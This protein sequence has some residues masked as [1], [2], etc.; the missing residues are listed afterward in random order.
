MQTPGIFA[1]R[2]LSRG[3]ARGASRGSLF[4]CLL[5][6]ALCGVLFAAFEVPAPVAAAPPGRD[7]PYWVDVP[8]AVYF[9]ET[10]HHLAEPFLFHWRMNGERA[11]FGLPISEAITQADGTVIQYF[12]RMALQFR[13]NS[14]GATALVVGFGAITNTSVNL[15]IGPGTS[16]GKVGVL[17][18]E[19]A[20][21]LVGGPLPDEDGAPWYQIAG[22]FGTGWTMG[23]FLERRDDPVS[24]ATLAVELDNPRTSE[25]AFAPLPPV[26][27]AALS[28]DSDE[29]TYFPTTGH[30]LAGAFYRYWR[31]NGGT[32]V[33]GLPISEPFDEVGADGQVRLTQY[34]E[35]ARMEFHAELAGTDGQVQLGLLGVRA[36]QVAR[37][38]T[39]P[40]EQRADAPVY[41]PDLFAGIQW[42]E[43]SISEQ[44]LTAWEGDLPIL[45]TLVRT[46]KP[47]WDTPRG[48]FRTFRKVVMEDMTLLDPSDPE[49]YYT[50]DVPWIM[51]FLEGG[52]AIHGAVWDDMWGTPTSHGCV[53]VP[54]DLAAFLYDWAP[55]GTLVW[56]HD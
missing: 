50:P 46:G 26:V 24:V 51:Y 27:V 4:R 3:A 32:S 15:R 42:I 41:S 53:N 23:E 33:F 10:G 54:V 47:G 31:A 5:A 25:R 18:A 45:T 34:F 39:R 38:N 11:I 37:V 29:H 7:L 28:P 6:L 21:R 30:S 52:F 44:R 56:I 48:T 13:P 20:V 12:E 2:S 17:G 16:W 40:A 8:D 9:A 55:L 14:G 19:E 36:A 43:V 22:T 1:G 49:Y 35:H